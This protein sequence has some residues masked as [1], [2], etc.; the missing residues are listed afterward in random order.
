M[1]ATLVVR[2]SVSDY[3]TWRAVYDE[4]ESLRAEHGCTDQRVLSAPGDGTD[5]LVTHDFGTVAQ[6]EGFAGSPQLREGMARA[7]VVGAPRIEI[8]ASV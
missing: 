6:A 4:L 7:G 5:L 1:S 3:A 2:H 8:F